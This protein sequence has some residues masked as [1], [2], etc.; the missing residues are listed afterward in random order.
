M[1][2]KKKKITAVQ[3]RSLVDWWPLQII[4]CQYSFMF[5]KNNKKIKMFIFLEQINGIFMRFNGK[6]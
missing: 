5:K 4:V 1:K 6:R 2:K 3:V